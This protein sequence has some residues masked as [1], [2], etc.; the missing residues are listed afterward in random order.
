[1]NNF[2]NKIAAPKCNDPNEV[3]IVT[4]Y[5]DNTCDGNGAELPAE[6]TACRCR[7]GYV[8][9]E[10]ACIKKCDCRM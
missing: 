6:V 7:R 5:G 3:Y 9:H 8:R 10:G 1:M 2:E 4:K